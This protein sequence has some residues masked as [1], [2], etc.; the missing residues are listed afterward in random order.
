[1]EY[2]FGGEISCKLDIQVFKKGLDIIGDEIDYALRHL[3]S[4]IL[5]NNKRNKL[6]FLLVFLCS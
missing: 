2:L 6:G 1:M 4:L 5:I 3:G